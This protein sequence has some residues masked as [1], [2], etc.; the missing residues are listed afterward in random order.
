VYDLSKENKDL[1]VPGQNFHE[2]IAFD[3][4]ETIL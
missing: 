3:D 4:I 2:W 1:V